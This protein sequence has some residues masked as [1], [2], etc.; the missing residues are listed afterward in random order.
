M[1]CL[2]EPNIFCYRFMRF[3]LHVLLHIALRNANRVQDSGTKIKT[4]HDIGKLL[5]VLDCDLMTFGRNLRESSL[6]TK[7]FLAMKC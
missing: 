3:V 7:N 4:G 5:I 2:E 1:T 6:V